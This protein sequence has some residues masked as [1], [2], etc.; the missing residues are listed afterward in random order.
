MNGAE[1]VAVDS[2]STPWDPQPR[3]RLPLREALL[4]ATDVAED[5]SRQLTMLS[6]MLG[7]APVVL[8]IKRQREIAKKLSDVSRRL[9]ALKRLRT[10]A[11]TGEQA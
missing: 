8:D 9:W 10:I 5:A 7:A 4:S 11:G 6:E 2:V 1:T 3:P